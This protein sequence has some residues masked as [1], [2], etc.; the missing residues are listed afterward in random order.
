MYMQLYIMAGRR[1]RRAA[2][3]VTTHDKAPLSLTEARATLS[4]IV[5]DLS[6]SVR[7]KVPIAVRGVVKA[8]VVSARRLEELEARER[9]G[10]A[11]ARPP[12]IRGTLEL[13]SRPAPAEGE[14]ASALEAQALASWERALARRR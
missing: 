2:A 8:Y 1:K 5:Q 12:R 7:V 4:P 9:A 14:A 3:P 11:G 13:G 6:T 10:R